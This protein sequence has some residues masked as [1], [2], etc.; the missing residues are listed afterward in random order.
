MQTLS[1]SYFDRH[2]HGE[3]M[4]RLTNDLDAI[5]RVI[6][7]NVIDL[8]SGLLTLIGGI[9]AMMFA[10][11]SWLALASMIVLPLMMLAGGVCGQAHAAAAIA[12]SRCASGS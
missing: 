4:S 8:F 9:V 10:L 12:S 11:N 2:P 7:Q 3:L 6:S 1:L 5:S